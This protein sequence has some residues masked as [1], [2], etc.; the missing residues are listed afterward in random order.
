MFFMAVMA[1]AAVAG[2]V[3]SANAAGAAGSAQRK[4]L[5]E[6]IYSNKME[7][8]FNEEVLKTDGMKAE[9][10]FSTQ[11]IHGLTALN[12]ILGEGIVA[13]GYKGTT[14]NTNIQKSDT[15]VW[16][17]D[18]KMLELNASHAAININ[19]QHTQDILGIERKNEAAASAATA[20][21]TA[22]N[23]A[24]QGAYI[25]GISGVASV[26]ATFMKDNPSSADTADTK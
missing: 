24:V 18:K 7:T 25:Q 4:S 21:K 8:A 5:H 17:Q 15:H 14:V 20:S 22:E 12:S 19:L 11:Y 6:G 23:Y 1:V 10:N 13:S 9:M 2:A 16:E 26:G 3:S